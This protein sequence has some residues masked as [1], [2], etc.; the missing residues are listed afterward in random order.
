MSRAVVF[1]IA[2]MF[3]VA[4]MSMNYC[5]ADVQVATGPLP[6]TGSVAR[7]A[8][9]RAQSSILAEGTFVWSLS[10]RVHRLAPSR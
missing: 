6:T 3:G 2:M 5:K 9:S 8:A 4:G 10:T 7:L 1:L